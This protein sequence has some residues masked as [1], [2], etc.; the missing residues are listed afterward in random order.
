MSATI[1]QAALRLVASR[2]SVINANAIYALAMKQG[3]EQDRDSAATTADLADRD[4]QR[5]LAELTIAADE[6]QRAVAERVANPDP[7]TLRKLGVI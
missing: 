5:A 7:D 3:T 1:V 4:F 6:F 2:R